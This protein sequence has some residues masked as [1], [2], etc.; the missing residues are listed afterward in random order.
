MVR[1]PAAL[2]GT[3]LA[4]FMLSRR[5]ASDEGRLTKQV[6]NCAFSDI[7]AEVAWLLRLFDDILQE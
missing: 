7:S 5:D 1:I 2:K 4:V 3:G 6:F